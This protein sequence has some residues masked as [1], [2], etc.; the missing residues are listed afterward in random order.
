MA[1]VKLSDFV[2]ET[3]ASISDGVRKAQEHSMKNDGVPIAPGNVDGEPRTEGNQMVKFSVALQAESAS[4]VDGKGELGGPIVSLVGGQAS[5]E[6]S[7]ASSNASS[8]TVE[9]SV[10]MHFNM[11]W[12]KFQKDSKPC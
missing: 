4:K 5:L 8:H 9:F 2:A 6:G 7:K 10:P 1:G 12:K 3:L 11:S